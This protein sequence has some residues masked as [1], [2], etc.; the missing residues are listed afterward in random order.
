MVE[1]KL[2]HV[3]TGKDGTPITGGTSRANRSA[4]NKPHSYTSHRG[5]QVGLRHLTNQHKEELEITPYAPLDD[6]MG[7]AFICAGLMEDYSGRTG[8][9]SDKFFEIIERYGYTFNDI[10]GLIPKSRL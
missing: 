2:V 9:S 6:L 5:A 8:E 7:L 4:A 3:I 10:D 1:T